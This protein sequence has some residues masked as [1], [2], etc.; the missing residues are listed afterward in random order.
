MGGTATSANQSAWGIVEL[1]RNPDLQK[2]L[3]EELDTVV[4]RD[5]LVSE[6]DIPKLPYLQAFVNETFRR[7][8]IIPTLIPHESINL[9]PVVVAGYE[10]PA[11]SRLL[12]NVYAIQTDPSIWEDPFKFDPERFLNKPI[13]VKG[14][15]FE[16]L[17]FGS[18]RRSC[19]GMMMGI[20]MVQMTVAQLA[21]SFEWSLPEGTDPAVLEDLETSKAVMGPKPIPLKTSL[22]LPSA[23][24]TMQS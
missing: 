23:L 17:P 20:L 1:V 5:R 21:Q 14:Q 11:K 10:I 22:R 24:Y 2:K 12:V 4:G 19:P 18:G 15:D 9:K 3:Q 13:Q 8:T 16:V 6:S 7:R